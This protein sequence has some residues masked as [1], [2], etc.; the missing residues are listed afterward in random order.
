MES[1]VCDARHSKKCTFVW[2]SSMSLRHERS[3]MPCTAASDEPN[4]VAR[5]NASFTVHLKGV[6]LIHSV[7]CGWA[8]SLR[9][10]QISPRR[11]KQVRAALAPRS[12]T[13]HRMLS[14]PSCCSTNKFESS[15]F[16]SDKVELSSSEKYDP[17]LQA[18]RVNEWCML[19]TCR[20]LNKSQGCFCFLVFWVVLMVT[21][22]RHRLCLR[23]AAGTSTKSLSLSTVQS[24]GSVSTFGSVRH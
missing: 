6:Q 13:C 1:T 15:S 20:M 23:A 14:L 10:A 17:K 9:Q 2:T 8:V 12:P 21:G 24:P 4:S 3:T 5:R 18:A 22:R 7:V 16:I 11:S 19:K